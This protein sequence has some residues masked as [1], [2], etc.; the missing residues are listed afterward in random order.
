[1]LA[2]DLGSLPVDD[3]FFLLG[4]QQKDLRKLCGKLREERMLAR[5][6]REAPS[7]DV[8]GLTMGDKVIPDKRSGRDSKDL[9]IESITTL[10]FTRQ[11][12]LLS[13]GYLTCPL[14]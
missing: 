14:R 8:S 2:D 10:T 9:S 3:L 5:Y 12:M 11:S 6:A 1:M 13:I 7:N 4:I